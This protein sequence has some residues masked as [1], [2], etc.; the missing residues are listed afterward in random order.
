M[1]L[2]LM[3]GYNVMV[4]SLVEEAQAPLEIV[5]RKT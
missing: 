1:L 4:T 2:L 5:H 3:A